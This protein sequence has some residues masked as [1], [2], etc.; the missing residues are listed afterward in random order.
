MHGKEGG[1]G[2]GVEGVRKLSNF[3]D[4]YMNGPFQKAEC[5]LN[6]Q[7]TTCL[8]QKNRAKLVIT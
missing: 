2:Q 7:S 4:V 8:S 3:C 5:T 6:P 1:R